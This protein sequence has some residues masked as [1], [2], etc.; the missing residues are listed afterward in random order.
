MAVEGTTVFKS[1]SSRS[2][3]YYDRWYGLNRSMPREERLE[4]GA[5]SFLCHQTCP[6]M[7]EIIIATQE[8]KPGSTG[9]AGGGIYF[10]EKAVMTEMKAHRRGSILSE[11]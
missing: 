8:M 11:N 5:R 2:E 4:R 7:A 9:L 1:M 3:V 10:A 6:E